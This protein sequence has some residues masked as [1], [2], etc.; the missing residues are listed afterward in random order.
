M[1]SDD[2]YPVEAPGWAAIDRALERLYPGVVPHQFASKTAYDL[3]SQSP[4][5]A[6]AAYEVSEPRLWHYVTYGL[7]ELFEKTSTR[8]DLSGFGFE[9]GLRLPRA[10]ETRPPS[11]PL[12][13]LQGIA[14][15]VLGGHGA[16]DSGHV[17]DLG[18]PLVP[19]ELGG[20]ATQLQGVL[21]VPDPLLGKIET[22]HGS[23]LFLTLLGLTR[24]E[25][26][27]VQDW[28]L[29]RKI[30]MFRELEPLAV[31]VPDRSSY[32]EDPAKAP[33]V[34]RYALGILLD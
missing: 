17:I 6:I 32:R 14:H 31:T 3:D 13:L 28:T 30:G 33:I 4:L 19:A 7:T 22:V 26:E 18:G 27:L 11:W 1:S 2:R 8:P 5:P 34:R 10:D 9:L 24:D 16:L 20:V 25:L 15:Y 21:C 12:R 29:E 23:I